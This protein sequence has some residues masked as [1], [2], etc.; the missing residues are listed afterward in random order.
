MQFTVIIVSSACTFVSIYENGR[1]PVVPWL[2]VQWPN[3]DPGPWTGVWLE[4]VGRRPC[5]GLGV[6]PEP[7]FTCVHVVTRGHV[8][9]QNAAGVNV[10]AHPGDLLSMWPGVGHRFRAEPPCCDEDTE[11]SWIRLLGPL[12]PEVL[13]RMGVSPTHP[14]APARDP[15]AAVATMAELYELGRRFPPDAD[16]RGVELI[17]RLARECGPATGTRPE[18]THLAEAVRREMV[19]HVDSRMNVADY[20]AMF[21]VSRVTLYKRFREAFGRSPVQVLN[22]IRLAH[23]DRLLLTTPLSVTEIASAAG[24]ASPLYFSRAFKKA[25]GLPPSAYRSR[26]TQC[27]GVDVPPLAEARLDAPRA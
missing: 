4:S 6:Q 22:E 23:A 9:L 10:V 2:I 25:R 11:L 8:R 15:N 18:Q 3:P 13:R 24:Y 16:V 21:G 20:A 12:A 5:I 1:R 19:H 26:G 17:Y 27:A 7:R 14:V